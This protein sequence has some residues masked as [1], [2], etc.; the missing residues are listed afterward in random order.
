MKLVDLDKC[1]EVLEKIK[2][3]RAVCNCGRK[4]IE[5]ANALG[6]AIA[7][8]KKLPIIEERNDKQ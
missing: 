5:Q 6:Y 4:S 2:K 1:I 8:L 3:E 7:I